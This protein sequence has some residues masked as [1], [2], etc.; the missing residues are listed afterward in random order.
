MLRKALS[1]TLAAFA[2]AA[3]GAWAQPYQ[4]LEAPQPTDGSGKI[5]V[6]EFFWYGC[7]HCYAME[8]NV[9]AWLKTK[10]ADVDFK[11]IPAYS[12]GW[13]PMASV[14]YTLEAMGKQE[15]MHAKVFDA[16]HKDHLNLN[17]RKVLDKFLADN[18]IDP[19]EY[20]KVEKSFS[21]VNKMNRDKQLTMLYLVDSV[22]RFFVAGKYV[23][24][25]EIAG[26]NDKIMGAIDEAVAA[27]R[28]E[29]H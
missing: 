6:I 2:F 8:P 16:I 21:V 7:P 17:S 22:P 24:S 1:L 10:P 27:V 19:V 11:R 5:E 20:E 3:A 13:I 23:T 28:K 9:A 4:K 18:G 25:G 15:A 26:G 12:G 14:F 29:K